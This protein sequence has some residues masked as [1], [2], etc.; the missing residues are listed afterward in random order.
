M[1]GFLCINVSYFLYKQYWC[2]KKLNYVYSIYNIFFSYLV[3][4]YQS[5]C[6]LSVRW[7]NE[8]NLP[9]RSKKKRK[10]LHNLMFRYLNESSVLHT[11]KERYAGNLIHTFAGPT[12][13][14]INPAQPLAIYSDKIIAMFKVHSSSRFPRHFHWR[15]KKLV[16]RLIFWLSLIQYRC[17]FETSK[18]CCGSKY[19]EFGC[20]SRLLALFGSVSMLMLSFFYIEC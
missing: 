3:N 15:R 16:N 18:Q 8:R 1:Y 2:C 20:G 4:A 7:W 17:I 13:I 10:D 19:N 12:M 5:N 6:P 9:L 11:L 14:S